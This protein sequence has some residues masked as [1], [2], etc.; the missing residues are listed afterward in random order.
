M[1]LRATEAMMLLPPIEPVTNTNRPSASVTMDGDIDERGALRGATALA[2]GLPSMKGSKAK[3]V[4]WLLS[5]KPPAMRCA[6]YSDSMV[7]VSA[8]A[9]PCESTIDKWVVPFSCIARLPQR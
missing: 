7:A 9:L 3:S 1:M 5:Q 4:S 2:T 8:T 6:P